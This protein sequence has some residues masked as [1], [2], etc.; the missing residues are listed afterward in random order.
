MKNKNILFLLLGM[1]LSSSAFGQSNDK[2][3]IFGDCEGQVQIT[4]PEN[5]SGH[6]FSK[7]C[8]VAWVLPPAKGTVKAVNVSP[9][10]ISGSICKQYEKSNQSLE[11]YYESILNLSSVSERI[12]SYI[13]DLTSERT[14][15][16]G[17]ERELKERR[18]QIRKEFK[19]VN[20]NVI[21]LRTALAELKEEYKEAT[22]AVRKW[23]LEGDISKTEDQLFVAEEEF[24]N[25]DANLEEVNYTIEDHK[26][27]LR[28]VKSELNEN[29]LQVG[30][31]EKEIAKV[32]DVVKNLQADFL[33][34]VGSRVTY[35]YDLP[36]VKL[37]KDYSDENPNAKVEFRRM[38]IKFSKLSVNLN[39]GSDVSSGTGRVSLPAAQV[40]GDYYQGMFVA[41][42]TSGSISVELNQAASCGM[43][44]SSSQSLNKDLAMS[45]DYFNLQN[46]YEYELAGE[47]GYKLKYDVMQFYKEKKEGGRRGGFFSSK[48]WSKE[49]IQSKNTSWFQIDFFSD[50]SGSNISPELEKQI[51][52]SEKAYVID[53]L[54]MGFLQSASNRGAAPIP[55]FEAGANG[56]Q[57]AAGELSKCP[58]LYCQ[59]GAAVL[60]LADSIWGSSK[61]ESEFSNRKDFKFNGLIRNQ[62]MYKS[63]GATGYVF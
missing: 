53:K 27:Y 33:T 13:D 22:D 12:S 37:M 8:S 28:S 11:K 49:T 32:I 25:L 50:S 4:E 1:S 3:Y 9:L 2:P 58:H 36:Y 52:A 35:E 6:K 16:L 21:R 17:I 54:F 24:V 55:G 31:N 18:N 48:S 60:R 23:Q 7:D 47:A 5:S 41:G 34:K 15:A 39:V 51:I 59:A 19:V 62:R 26:D 57:T 20:S 42:P 29:Q 61:A 30:A 10:V 40:G 45:N 44:D 43:W 46:L 56:A 63:K 38:P 14:S